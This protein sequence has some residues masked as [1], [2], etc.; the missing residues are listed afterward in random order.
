M[1]LGVL[2]RSKPTQTYVEE[3]NVHDGEG[4]FAIVQVGDQVELLNPNDEFT[5]RFL[6]GPGP[7]TITR[8]GQWRC[9]RKSLYIRTRDGEPGAHANIFKIHR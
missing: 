9:G 6:S 8:I 7:Y 4:G 3:A 1:Y 2:D 5:G